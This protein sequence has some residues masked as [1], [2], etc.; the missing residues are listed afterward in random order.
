MTSMSCPIMLYKSPKNEKFTIEIE[1]AVPKVGESYWRSYYLSPAAAHLPGAPCWPLACCRAA[2]FTP[3]L[4]PACQPRW[5]VL[6]DGSLQRNPTSSPTP[7]SPHLPIR[8]PGDH[9]PPAG[10][11]FG[12][13]ADRFSR[14]ASRFSCSGR[15]SPLGHQ[16]LDGLQLQDRQ[17]GRRHGPRARMTAWCAHA[18]AMLE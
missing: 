1:I 2:P 13:C 7:P 18:R 16:V 17:S 10:R 3:S 4:M 11:R 14:R 8:P 15:R 12:R 9:L 6:H 5:P